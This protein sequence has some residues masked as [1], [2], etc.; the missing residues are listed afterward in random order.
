MSAFRFLMVGDSVTVGA[1]FSGVTSTTS[2]VHLL[3][4]QLGPEH[5]VVA[6]ALDGVDSGYALKR[7]DR[8]VTAHHPDIVV[9]MLGL[10]D[11]QP[12]GGRSGTAPEEYRE[13]LTRLANRIREIDA[14]PILAT[15][16]PRLK[17][18]TGGWAEIMREYVETVRRVADENHLNCIN[19]YDRFRENDRWETL[20]PDGVHPGP[21]G[22][23]IIAGAFVQ[24]LA[25]WFSRQSR[26]ED[27][28]LLSAGCLS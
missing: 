27:P 4:E 13:N 28:A 17:Q 23:R 1:P 9:V 18:T 26:V 12:P 7:F 14:K 19:V 22:H 15:P 25:P 10:N 6:S 3:R 16:T 21:T 8:M 20:I 5:D 2:Y 11:A 24:A